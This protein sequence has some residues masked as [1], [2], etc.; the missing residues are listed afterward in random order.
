MQTGL[1]KQWWRLGGAASIGFVVLF[2]IALVIEGDT[3]MTD[4]SAGEVRSYFADNRDRFLVGEFLI[5][6][7]FVFFFLPFMSALRTLLG[8]AEGG[9]QTWSR[10]AFAA[11]VLALAGGIAASGSFGA[12]AYAAAD[13]ADDDLVTTLVDMNYYTF[14][15]AVPML[16]ALVLMST[17]IVVLRTAVLWTWI[18]WFG[19]ALAAAAVV[20][21]FAILDEDP[22]GPLGILGLAV[23]IAW[24]VWQLAIGFAMLRLSEEPGMVAQPA[25]GGA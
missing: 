3:P 7:G 13:K 18:G 25:A 15:T 19:L 20:S 5:G 23:F 2:I 16:V 4:D 11:A 21:T 1:L 22:Q 17:S 12:L 8:R 14:T 6:L 9:A 24:G 10:L